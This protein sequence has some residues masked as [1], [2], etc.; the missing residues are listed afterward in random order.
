MT[1]YV[2]VIL[3]LALLYPLGSFSAEDADLLSKT[4]SAVQYILVL[5]ITKQPLP[6][7]EAKRYAEIQLDAM[8]D[9]FSYT[10]N[11]NPSHYRLGLINILG[12]T[13]IIEIH[14]KAGLD[15]DEEELLTK[16]REYP[17]DTKVVLMRTETYKQI[18]HP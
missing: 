1:K 6:G 10:E 14:F 17:F 12:H 3:V 18:I 4:P 9:L 7:D 15:I 13:R 8:G 2:Y 16:L 5:D 11:I